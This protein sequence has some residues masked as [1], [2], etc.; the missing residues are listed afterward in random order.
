MTRLMESLWTLCCRWIQ[1]AG[2]LSANPPRREDRALTSQTVRSIFRCLS[3][4]PNMSDHLRSK[5]RPTDGN[6][7]VLRSLRRVRSRDYSMLNQIP[8]EVTNHSKA[9]TAGACGVP[10]R[11]GFEPPSAHLLPPGSIHT[12]RPAKRGRA[13]LGPYGKAKPRPRALPLGFPAGQE[14]TEVL[15]ALSL[16]PTHRNGWMRP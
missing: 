13:H 16:S 10:A 3:A 14:P 5:S 1:C 2:L 15:M 11:T 8:T 9:P 7:E 6:C 12:E 4:S